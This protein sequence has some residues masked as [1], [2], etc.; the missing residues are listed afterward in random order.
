MMNYVYKMMNSV[1]NVMDYVWQMMDSVFK[2]MDS[3]FKMMNLLVI[4]GS[5]IVTQAEPYVL[6]TIFVYNSVV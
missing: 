1:S 3:V 5:W 2:M 6:R 4:S